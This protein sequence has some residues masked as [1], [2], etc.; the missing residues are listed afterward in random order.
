MKQRERRVLSCLLQTFAVFSAA[1]AFHNG[2]MKRVTEPGR[3][4]VWV[5]GDSANGQPAEFEIE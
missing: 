1:L 4:Q 2:E 5:S 3:Y